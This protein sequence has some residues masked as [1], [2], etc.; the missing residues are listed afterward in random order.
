MEGGEE[1]SWRMTLRDEIAYPGKMRGDKSKNT[2][3][4]PENT[5][6]FFPLRDLMIETTHVL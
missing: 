4:Q 5:E 2:S 3:R 6:G 1:E